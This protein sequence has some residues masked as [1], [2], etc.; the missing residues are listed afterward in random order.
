MS[1]WFKLAAAACGSLFILTGCPGGGTTTDKCASVMCSADKKC[2]PADGV[3]K[4]QTCSPACSGATPACRNGTCVQCIDD[5]T[6]SGATPLCD[7]TTY[8]CKPGTVSNPDGGSDGGVPDGGPPDAGPLVC[9]PKI[10]NVNTAGI[11]VGLAFSFLGTLKDAGNQME[12]PMG[13]QALDD[14]GNLPSGGP[15]VVH[16]YTMPVAGDLI[17]TTDAPG[18]EADTVLYT[19]PACVPGRAGDAGVCN[20]D[21]DPREGNFSSAIV[22]S[23]VPS[24]RKTTFMVDGYSANSVGPATDDYELNVIVRAYADAGIDCDTQ[25]LASRCYRGLSCSFA[26]KKCEQGVGPTITSLKVFPTTATKRLIAFSGT[27]VQSDAW[28]LQV[29]ALN[30]ADAGIAGASVLLQNA[31]G[32]SAFEEAVE[33][34]FG[35]FAATTANVRATLVDLGNTPG[36][37]VTAGITALPTIPDGGVCGS[38]LTGN[39]ATGAYCRPGSPG[40]TQGLCT[41]PTAPVFVSANA[42]YA[43]PPAPA[44]L[45]FRVTDPDMDLALA[46]VR[47]R[48]ADGGIAIISDGGTVEEIVPLFVEGSPLVGVAPLSDVIENTT[49]GRASSVDVTFEDSFGLKTAPTNL[50]LTSL[51]IVDAGTPCELTGFDQ[52][53]AA[54]TLCYGA[55]PTC[56]APQTA[57]AAFCAAPTTIALGTPVTTTLPLGASLYEVP[58]APRA[59]GTER[60]FKFTTSVPTNIKFTANFPETTVIPVLYTSTMCG[61]TVTMTGCTNGQVELDGIW[62]VETGTHYLFVDSY[63][64]QQQG[65][66]LKFLLTA[67]PEIAAGG[68]CDPHRS[69]NRCAPNLKCV[70]NTDYLSYSC[71]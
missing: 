29:L 4:V 21:I 13:C 28:S 56:Q 19:V 32:K 70:P 33:I 24:G 37:P 53:C 65:G 14:E 11:Q 50:A 54:S 16:E 20:D 1:K 18:T 7:F 51:P 49:L 6:C 3:C 12:P 5:T 57:I 64:A 26:T 71:K 39:C 38:V 61:E 45:A 17:L 69:E 27:D 52:L 46:H 67:L 66:T 9:S 58:C 62:R 15:D 35:G 22:V 10:V 63:R 23:N 44:R 40:A 36:A 2:D 31:Y 47:Y 60:V 34:D 30:A 68:S 55:S 43:V 48:R 25:I 8:T 59:N 42:F 41:T